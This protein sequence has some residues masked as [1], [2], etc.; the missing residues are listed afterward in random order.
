LE[1]APVITLAGRTVPS[2][3][4]EKF[5]MW[6]QGAYNPLFMKMP[7]M[8]GLDDYTIVKKTLALPGQL[9]IYHNGCDYETR[10][11]V[12]PDDRGNQDIARDIRVT[13]KNI[14][15]FWINVY[16]LMGDFRRSA[17]SFAA[18]GET[19]VDDAQLIHIEGYKL[20]ASEQARFDNWFNVWASRIYIPLLLKVLGVKAS[21][22]FR[23][24][25]YRSPGYAW[26]NFVESDMPAF[27]SVTYFENAESLDGFN[28]S[29][30]LAAFRQ[31][32]MLEFPDNFKTIW[33]TEYRLFS[34]FRP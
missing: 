8:K 14:T 13:F 7:G 31:T 19:V 2:S 26:A 23:L 20:A 4:E 9:S 30:E 12:V 6:R 24:M 15:W 29:V 5:N 32:L 11:K 1:N 28:Q 21:N 10:K 34:S 25:D 33:D 3:L 18:R 17:G 27:I 22:F 16:E